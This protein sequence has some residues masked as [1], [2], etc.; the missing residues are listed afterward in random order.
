[1]DITT[2]LIVLI[3]LAVFGYIPTWDTP[4]IYGTHG[5]V[6]VLLVVLIVVALLRMRNKL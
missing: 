6:G 1:M 3:V 2:I 4:Y 5:I